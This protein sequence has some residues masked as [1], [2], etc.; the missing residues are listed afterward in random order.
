VAPKKEKTM[1][2]K[3]KPASGLDLFD[4]ASDCDNPLEIE[5]EDKFGNKSGFYVR[6]KGRDS[7]AYREA[8]EHKAAQIAKRR[9]L[10]NRRGRGDPELLSAEEVLS[11]QVDI[12]TACTVGFRFDEKWTGD[13]L[14]FTPEAARDLYTKSVLIRTQISETVENV[15]VFI[16]R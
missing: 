9:A 15:E 6:L 3:S 16:N 5:L 7:Q 4:T 11:I 8:Q 13:P 12:L 1:T 10:A 2:A 14:A